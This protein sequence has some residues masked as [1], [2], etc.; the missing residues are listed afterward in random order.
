MQILSYDG[1][2]EGW[3][4]SVFIVYEY[5]FGDVKISTKENLQPSIFG[6]V[7]PVETNEVKALRVMSGLKKKISSSALRQLHNSLL[8]EIPGIEDIMLSYCRHAFSQKENIEL[9]FS[10]AAV[11]CIQQTAKK[12]HR[13]KHRMEAF[14][15][16]QLTTDQIYF[17][18][19]EP[20]FNVL[21]LIINHFEKRYADQQWLIFDGKRKYGFFYDLN[22]VEAVTIN[23]DQQNSS[24]K[25]IKTIHSPGELLY[26]DLW[27]TYF[28]S[29]NIQ[30]RK[31]TRL[32]IQHM[33]KRYWKFLTE[34]NY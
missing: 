32:H 4:T 30:A 6:N 28:K 8:S 15:R 10:H 24:G 22:R 1:S 3:L 2:F 5:G 31:N 18:I 21:P 16:F 17:A 11:L 7:M 34:K 33:P 20:D 13:E 12:V 27:K 9:D 26:Q 25:D 29:V 19:C 23:F 14:I